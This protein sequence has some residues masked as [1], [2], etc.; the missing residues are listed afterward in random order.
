M[1]TE[2]EL[3]TIHLEI[4]RK[5]ANYCTFATNKQVEKMVEIFS[6]DSILLM[7]N[8]EIIGKKKIKEYYKGLLD[9]IRFP[10]IEI[11]SQ[12]IFEVGE[13]RIYEMGTNI[14]KYSYNDTI[15][16][17]KGNYITIWGKHN[18]EWLIHEDLIPPMP[19]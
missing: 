19:E 9:N 13:G 8:T 17:M 2:K 16:K 15:M 14:I 18:N 4:K 11:S 7:Q 5:L 10:V 3:E 1:Y 12:S 6:E